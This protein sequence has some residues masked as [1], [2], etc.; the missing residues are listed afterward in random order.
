[1]SPGATYSHR[2]AGRRINAPGVANPTVA[3]AFA[4]KNVSAETSWGWSGHAP[5]RIELA[6]LARRGGPPAVLRKPIGPARLEA[7]IDRFCTVTASNPI[8]PDT[9]NPA[10]GGVSLMRPTGWSCGPLRGSSLLSRKNGSAL[11][12][13]SCRIESN[14]R[15]QFTGECKI[16]GT[17]SGPRRSCARQDSNL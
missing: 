9:R 5:D 8:P 15:S 10:C 2:G 13:R 11:R 6:T 17:P 3:G 7:V 4:T 16:A 12:E 14:R 1:M